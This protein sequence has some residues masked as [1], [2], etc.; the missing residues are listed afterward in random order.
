MKLPVGD[1]RFLT[2]KKAWELCEEPFQ[3]VENASGCL[4][5]LKGAMLGIGAEWLRCQ[6]TV[7]MV[8]H[9]GLVEDDLIPAGSPGRFWSP[10]DEVLERFEK[11]QEMA[12]AVAHEKGWGIGV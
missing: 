8:N 10:S 4:T 7:R 3:I 5:Q 11:L 9:L 2:A 1:T 12:K 6:L